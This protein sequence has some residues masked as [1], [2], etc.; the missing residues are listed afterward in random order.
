[1]DIIN[2][3]V[4]AVKGALGMGAGVT[5]QAKAKF[6]LELVR[7]GERWATE[8]FD[9]ARDAYEGSG[10]PGEEFRINL[11]QTGVD[12]RISFLDE[13]PA[14]V[15]VVSKEG[16]A[17]DKAA[18]GRAKCD[19]AVLKYLS[20]EQNDYQVVQ[21]MLHSASITNMGCVV[22]CVDRRRMLP[23][24]KYVEN[25]QVVVDPDSGGNLRNASWLG[26]WEFVAP[27]MLLKDKD[28]QH[29]DPDKLKKA[30]RLPPDDTTGNLADA[31]KNRRTDAREVVGPKMKKCKLYRLWL[32]N[33][34]AL[35]DDDP[36]AEKAEN[37]PHVERFRDKHGMD[38]PRRY[39]EVIEGYTESVVKDEAAWPD[40]FA[41]DWDEWP[42]VLLRF[43][44]IHQK[45]GAFP[46]LRNERKVLTYLEKAMM[47][48]NNVM[49]LHTN[50][51][52]GTRQG[53]TKTAAELKMAIESQGVSI[54]EGILD[55]QGQPMIAPLNFGDL[56]DEHLQWIALCREIHETISGI[57]KLKRGEED[58][59]DKMT[60]TE[61]QIVSDAAEVRM[62]VRRREFENAQCLIRS[63]QLQMA[64]V[65]LKRNS[66]VQLP[67]PI[68]MLDEIGNP[69][70]GPDGQPQMNDVADGLPWPQAEELVRAGGTLVTLGVDAMVGP[71][72]AEFWE[73]EVPL[74]VIRR[75]TRVSVERGSTQRRTRL[76]QE[77]AFRET[78]VQLIQPL[79]VLMGDIPKQIEAAKKSLELQGLQEFERVLP[80]LPPTPQMGP[81][82]PGPTGVPA[83]VMP[84]AGSVP[85]QQG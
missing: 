25:E 65:L 70:I 52:L 78:Y 5:E 49:A 15:T 83:E 4:G 54:I 24:I 60:A 37:G 12:T 80:E 58:T 55:A 28:Y 57:P 30:A 61:A 2:G 23:T 43:R 29:L 79:L 85:V 21:E 51:K 45:I 7:A 56:D 82:G 74:D 8:E 11:W 76:L 32:R 53:C 69:V 41:L 84:G 63:M 67:E 75:S 48:A 42:L 10:K 35:Y 50:Q 44:K 47:D 33:E 22:G 6:F 81:A 72:L 20:D 64:H 16:F 3:I 36:D 1:M 68:P 77:K 73:D 59:N 17:N 40:A 14:K 46:E 19:T 39:I 9:E 38:E 71:E 26:Y 27:D 66:S 31:E 13:E 18:I 34:I 62:A